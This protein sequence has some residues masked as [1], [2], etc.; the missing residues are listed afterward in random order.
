MIWKV[1]KNPRKRNGDLGDKKCSFCGSVTGAYVI[2]SSF[3]LLCRKCLED[4]IEA[5]N[6]AILENGE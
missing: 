5:I 4:G 3:Y 6:K 2:N 1:V